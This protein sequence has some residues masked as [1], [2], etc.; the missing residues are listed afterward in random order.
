MGG[1]LEVVLFLCRGYGVCVEGVPCVDI[2]VYVYI[3]RIMN[4]ISKLA[5]NL[6][7]YASSK[8]FTVY[9]LPLFH[10]T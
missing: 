4:L 5:V 9:V 6:T 8:R 7:G 1:V 3:F 2:L 10:S